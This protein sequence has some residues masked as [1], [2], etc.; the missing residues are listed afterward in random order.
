MTQT[1]YWYDFETTGIDSRRDRVV[2]FAG[3]R[4]D[5]DFNVIAEPDVFYCRLQ[6]DVL[7]HPDAC[8]V[9]GISP[10]KTLQEGLLEPDFIKRIHQQFSTP[11]TCV[12]GFNSI[13]FDDEFT[14]QLLYRNFYDP[15]AREWKSGNSRWDIIDV[16]R[17]MYALRPDGINWP[18]REDG[19]VSFKLELLTAANNISHQSAHDALSDVYATIAVAKLIKEKQPRLY[20]WAYSLKDKRKALECLNLQQKPAIVHVSGKYPAAKHCLAVVMPLGAH[21]V[22]KNS[23]IA[24]DLSIDPAAMLSM[25]ADE[26]YQRLYTST[27][28]LAEGESRIPLKL[29]HA[30]KSPMLA[31][32]STLNGELAKE[33]GVDLV[34]CERNR[35]TLLST[36]IND[37]LKLV[38]SKNDFDIEEDPDMMLYGGGFFSAIDNEN[39]QQIRNAAPAQL[40]G[41]DLPFDD[42]RLEEMLFRYRARN[43]PETLSNEEQNRWLAHRKAWLEKGEGNRLDLN[44]Y[45]DRIDELVSDETLSEDQQ[46]L[47]A[48]LIEFGS[49]YSEQLGLD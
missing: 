1:L 25:T 35:Q 17:L 7:P 27:D 28:D 9:T 3:V 49:D 24:C 5:L 4:T 42:Q 13:R 39:M 48:Q 31:P 11:Q 37:K 14:R 21:P 10:Q 29:I 36:A 8:L 19:Q 12:A 23:V 40:A 2:Q 45:F 18:K 44:S 16:V 38:F 32:L 46:E 33:L 15:Y 22:N 43:Y 30:N 34:A 6:D 47:L 41:L 20:D 26:I